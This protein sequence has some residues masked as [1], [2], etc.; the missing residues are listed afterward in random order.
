MTGRPKRR[1]GASFQIF[2]FNGAAYAQ[3]TGAIALDIYIAP[4]H[5]YLIG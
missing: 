4:C 5:L 1:D 3:D 2:W